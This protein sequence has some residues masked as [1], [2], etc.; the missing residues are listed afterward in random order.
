MRIISLGIDC[1]PKYQLKR[2][3]G[4]KHSSLLFDWV[5]SSMESVINVLEKG[6]S[7]TIH[8][9]K[10]MEPHHEFHRTALVDIPDLYSYHDLIIGC[11]EGDKIEFLAKMNRRHRRF[12]EVV[13]EAESILFIRREISTVQEAPREFFR[14]LD[15]WAGHSRHRL[16]LLVTPPE[17]REEKISPVELGDRTSQIELPLLITP[18]REP[19]WTLSEYDW[20]SALEAAIQWGYS[21]PIPPMI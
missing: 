17:S 10:L 5:V 19:A 11:N 2:L 12:L 14:V 15:Q 1:V 4:D 13:K 3:F 16:A 21:I 8:N 9:L 7:I 20:S 6:D 18:S